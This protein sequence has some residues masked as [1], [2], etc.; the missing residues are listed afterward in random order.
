ME[1][2]MP[3]TVVTADD[4]PLLLDAMENLFRLQKDIK[5]VARCLDGN[6]AVKAVRRYKPDI[7]VL[8]IRMPRKDGLGVLRE[9]KKENLP[10]RVV[11]LTATLEEEELAEAIRLG[12]RGLVLKELAPKLIV[13]CIR[14]V[15]A[16]EL[17]LEKHSVSSALEKLLKREAGRNEAVRVLTSREIEI[18]KH[19][20]AGLRNRE[21]AKKLFISEG[22]IKVH[23]HTIYEKLGIRSRLELS[24]YA[25]D[26]GL[27]QA[28]SE[29]Q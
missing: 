3:I 26:K 27:V 29:K 21:I 7:L 12:V 1:A 20:A 2:E 9:M 5:V 4:H 18:V 24:L 25:R 19:A 8:D 14:K 22:T 23:L 11:V 6:E 17:W 10:T 16:G 15:H 28:E 13:Q